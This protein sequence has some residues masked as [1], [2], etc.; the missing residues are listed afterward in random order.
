MLTTITYDDGLQITIT[1]ATP[2]DS[3]SGERAFIL[4]E[5]ETDAQLEYGLDWDHPAAVFVGTL[6]EY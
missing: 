1:A 5:G 2:G 3:R 4:P 6:K